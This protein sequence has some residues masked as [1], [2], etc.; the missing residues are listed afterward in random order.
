MNN[1]IFI[2]ALII[3]HLRAQRDVI[4]SIMVLSWLPCCPWRSLLSTVVRTPLAAWDMACWWVRAAFSSGRCP[5]LRGWS[6]PGCCSPCCRKPSSASAC[7]GCAKHRAIP[8]PRALWDLLR[9]LSHFAAAWPLLSRIALSH[10]WLALLF[11]FVL[12]RFSKQL[13]MALF[14]MIFKTR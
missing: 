9:P 6:C 5:H 7:G 8:V 13:F 2:A 1:G 11:I 3:P 14:H 12:E 4:V 10:P